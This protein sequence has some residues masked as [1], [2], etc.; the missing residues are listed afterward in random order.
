MEQTYEG[1]EDDERFITSDS[2]RNAQ[3]RLQYVSASL[4]SPLSAAGKSNMKKLQ[5]SID[6][7][8]NQ[9]AIPKI[10][11]ELVRNRNDRVLR[12]SLDSSEDTGID[13][14]LSLE[15]VNAFAMSPSIHRDQQRY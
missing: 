5:Q 14:S 10:D 9:K 6:L 13:V 8:N 11:T 15:D 4:T 2:N 1:T 12:T 3:Q 7:P